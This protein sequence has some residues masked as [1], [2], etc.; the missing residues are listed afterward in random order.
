MGRTW[1][2]FEQTCRHITLANRAPITLRLGRVGRAGRRLFL[3]SIN[4]LTYFLYSFRDELPQIR[5]Q[6]GI[7]VA[8]MGLMLPLLLPAPRLPSSQ[9]NIKFTVGCAIPTH[10]SHSWLGQK[11]DLC[12]QYLPLLLVT[13]EVA[14]CNICIRTFPHLQYLPHAHLFSLSRSLE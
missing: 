8:S 14:F 4:C 11:Y 3:T 5:R 13:A 9:H 2:R 12:M 10:C 7:L 6:R 1:V